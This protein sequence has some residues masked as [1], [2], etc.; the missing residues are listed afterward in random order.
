[1]ENFVSILFLLILSA[2][3]SGSETAFLSANKLLLELNRSKHPFPAKII[4]VF[5]QHPSTFLSTMLMGNTIVLVLY[6]LKMADILSPLMVSYISSGFLLLVTQIT[7]STL[8]ILLTSEFLP[9]TVFRIDPLLALNILAIPMALSYVLLYPFSKFT[10]W[11]SHRTIKLVSPNEGGHDHAIPVLGRLDLDNLLLVHEEK[12]ATNEEIPQEVKMLR[13]A[14]DFSSIKIRECTVPRTDIEAVEVH[15]SIENLK[16]R[17]TE[18]GFSKIMIYKDTIDNIIGYV[19]VSELFKH[20][21]ALRSMVNPISVIPETM[22]A[23]KVLEIFTREHKSIALVV[24]EFGGTA[25]IVTME[26]ILEEIF[27]EIDDEHD[28][29]DLKIEQISPNE[30]LFSGKVEVDAI[31]EKFELGLPYSDEYETI[32]GLLL[33][34]HESIPNPHAVILVGKFEFTIESASNNRIELVKL[35]VTD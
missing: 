10:I 27:G 5:V 15:E 26:D 21:K 28:V 22:T 11:L 19:H 34:Y 14:L 33:F 31:N 2:F 7:I 25:G 1:M 24:D 35:R 18:T 3:F 17:F 6:G 20:P 9:K 12:S 16:Q 13:N 8:I 30:F 23:N 32:A 4:D 29:S